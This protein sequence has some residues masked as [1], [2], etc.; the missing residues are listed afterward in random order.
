M[1][2]STTRSP[3]R[4][5][6]RR[7][8]AAELFARGWSDIEV[9]RELGVDKTTAIRYRKRY[10]AE[11]EER[12]AERP[13]LLRN[14]VENT[15]RAIAELDQVR[16]AA[17]ADYERSNTAAAKSSFLKV[18]LACQVE[19]AKLFGLMGVKQEFAHHVQRVRDL[20]DK[21]IEFMQT[22]L[23]DVDRQSLLEFLERE[24]GGETLERL[25]TTDEVEYHQG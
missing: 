1:P 25:P 2:R 21:L 12:V 9:A 19:R 18:A 16:A 15:F 22:R 7:E 17:W 5:A 6:A 4:V 23:C 11:L 24:L 10:E 3:L 8:R 14:V 13:D 20:Q